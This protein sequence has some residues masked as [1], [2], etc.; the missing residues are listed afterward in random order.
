[1]KQDIFDAN[2]RAY[3]QVQREKYEI[4]KTLQNTLKDYDIVSKACTRCRESLITS[5]MDNVRNFSGAWTSIAYDEIKYINLLANRLER[6]KINGVVEFM[7]FPLNSHMFQFL[8][9]LAQVQY[10]NKHVSIC[11]SFR[12]NKIE[13]PYYEENDKNIIVAVCVT[14]KD[15]ETMEME[16]VINL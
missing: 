10:Q 5:L 15:Q 6:I 16:F 11:H 7:D 3:E 13:I 9:G 14:T 1:M 2:I 12:Y 4:Y 8:D